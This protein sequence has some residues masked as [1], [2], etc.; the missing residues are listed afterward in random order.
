[1]NVFWG[2]LITTMQQAL[3]FIHKN[4]RLYEQ[5]I[6]IILNVGSQCKDCFLNF[7]YRGWDFSLPG[8]RFSPAW[9]HM[10]FVVGDV[11]WSRI[12]SKILR[13]SPAIISSPLLH[14]HLWPL[15]KRQNIITFSVYKVGIHLWPGTLLVT[16]QKHKLVIFEVKRITVR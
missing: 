5:F 15:L 4:W 16:K 10:S 11:A 9:L 14:A 2:T 8:P 7:V 1:M 3:W 13:F 12:F 6:G